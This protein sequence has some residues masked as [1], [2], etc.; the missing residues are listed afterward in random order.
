MKRIIVLLSA[1]FL[2]ALGVYTSGSTNSSNQGSASVR[3]ATWP[4]GDWS[5][6][7]GPTSKPGAVV[8]VYQV[9]TEA[10]QGLKVTKIAVRNRSPKRVAAIS[11]SWQLFADEQREVILAKGETQLLAFTLPPKARRIVEFPVVTF[12]DIWGTLLRDGRLDGRF[13]IEVA[14]A[15]V[16]FE[17]KARWQSLPSED[18]STLLKASWQPGREGFVVV[19]SYQD[20]IEIEEDPGAGACA[21]KECFWSP[22][23]NKYKCQSKDGF[24][25]KVS[26]SGQSC[27]E[28]R[29]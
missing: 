7:C 27:T 19:T 22:I 13:R 28:S 18:R 24:G 14:I 11:V 25:C 1:A 21:H 4:S 23:D 15:E 20:P 26:G 12:R 9:T 6:V 2:F 17:D 8:D 29:C 3:T 16:V 5:L 10:G